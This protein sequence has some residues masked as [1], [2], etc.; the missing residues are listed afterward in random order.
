MSAL[1]WRNR[2]IDALVN[3]GVERRAAE[4]IYTTT[5]SKE[6]A[7][8]S[9]SPEIQAMM[10]LASSTDSKPAQKAAAQH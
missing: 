9:K 5:Y 10:V 7:D 1:Y 3:Q 2:W 6:P 4:N 8:Q